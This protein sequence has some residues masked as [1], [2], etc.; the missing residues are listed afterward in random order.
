MRIITK[1]MF[2]GNLSRFTETKK[3]KNPKGKLAKDVIYYQLSKD[4]FAF[5]DYL[6][7]TLYYEPGSEDLLENN[8]WEIQKVTNNAKSFTYNEFSREGEICIDGYDLGDLKEGLQIQEGGYLIHDGTGQFD[9]LYFEVK[10]IH[11]EYTSSLYICYKEKAER[12]CTENYDDP[13][14]DF[15]LNVLWMNYEKLSKK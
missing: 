5:Y 15:I 1:E 4:K 7:Q 11:S 2:K 13:T 6:Q 8:T 10:Y 3:Y 12:S 14:I 9:D